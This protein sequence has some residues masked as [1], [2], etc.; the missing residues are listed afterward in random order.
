MTTPQ[1][2]RKDTPTTALKAVAYYRMS[3]AKQ[4]QSIPKPRSLTGTVF[5]THKSG[6]LVL[7]ARAAKGKLRGDLVRELQPGDEFLGWT[8]AELRALGK[9]EHDLQERRLPSSA[10]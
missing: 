10:R 6:S 4:D 2:A 8:Y 1:R 7:M 9:G 5:L 3:T